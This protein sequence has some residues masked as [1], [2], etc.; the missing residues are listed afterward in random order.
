MNRGTAIYNHETDNPNA[1]KA[2]SDTLHD[3]NFAI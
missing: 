2:L 1:N 3:E